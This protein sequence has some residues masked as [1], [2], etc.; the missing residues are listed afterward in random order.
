MLVLCIRPTLGVKLRKSNILIEGDFCEHMVQLFLE[1]LPTSFPQTI[2]LLTDIFSDTVFTVCAWLVAQL[3]STLCDPV[4]RS[5][6]GSF[7]HGISHARVLEWVAISSSRG[8]SWPRYWTRVSCIGRQIL[9]HWATREAHTVFTTSHEPLKRGSVLCSSN[10]QKVLYLNQKP[11]SL[12]LVLPSGTQKIKSELFYMAALQI[13]EDS[14]H[15]F[16]MSCSCKLTGSLCALYG[17]FEYR[18]YSCF[19]VSVLTEIILMLLGKRR[20]YTRENN[21]YF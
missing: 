6:P 18:I 10:F 14:S 8:S 9:Y 1:Y 13:F 12:K 21:Q 16:L 19:L 20:C 7:A 11:A 15:I 4:D 3:C 17:T 5:S 2:F